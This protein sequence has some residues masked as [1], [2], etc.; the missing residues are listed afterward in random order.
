MIVLNAIFRS[1]YDY[2]IRLSEDETKSVNLFSNFSEIPFTIIFTMEFVL[3]AI[4]VG[5]V[6]G[7]HAMLKDTWNII[8]FIAVIFG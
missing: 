1:I 3:K 4:A 2:S 6:R 7:K 5:F 8:D